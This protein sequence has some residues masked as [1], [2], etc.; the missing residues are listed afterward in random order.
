MKTKKNYG[1]VIIGS[2]SRDNLNKE[3]LRTPGPGAYDANVD[4]V[5]LKEH[6]VRMGTSQRRPLSAATKHP[7]PGAYEIPSKMF[8][9]PKVMKCYGFESF[10]LKLIL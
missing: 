10:K 2:A 7:G 6:G 8:E 3:Q 5:K 1:N 4:G 9:G